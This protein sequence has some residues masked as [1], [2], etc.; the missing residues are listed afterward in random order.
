MND[1]RLY[2]GQSTIS[3]LPAPGFLVSII[4]DLLVY[5]KGRK[6]WSVLLPFLKAVEPQNRKR[7]TGLE[8]DLMIARG[9][10]GRMGRRDS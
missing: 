9:L 3:S 1:S 4:T 2:Q 5:L 7:L 6:S 8:N 10:G